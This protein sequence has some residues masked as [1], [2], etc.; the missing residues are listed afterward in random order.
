MAVDNQT[1]LVRALDRHD[2]QAVLGTPESSWVDFKDP[3]AYPLDTET[4][5]WELAKDVAAMANADGGLLVI[6]IY[7]KK[8]PHDTHEMASDLRPFSK[9]TYK[10]DQLRSVIAS[11]LTPSQ[12]VGMD[13]FPETPGSDL[14]YLVITVKPVPEADRYV[15]TMKADFDGGKIKPAIG[16]PVRAG[17]GT[18]WLS[19]D[20]IYRLVNDGWRRRREDGAHRAS[21]LPAAFLR[22]GAQSRADGDLD[23]LE[24]SLGWWDKPT[25]FWQ[26]YA[27]PGTVDQVN[28]YSHDG[29]RGFLD[30]PNALRGSGF[31]FHN[32]Y[33]PTTMLESGLLLASRDGLAVHIGFDGTATA[34]AVANRSILARSQD[35]DEGLPIS[36]IVLTELTYEY[37]RL[38]D[39]HVLSLAPGT[40]RHRVVVRRLREHGVTLSPGETGEYGFGQQ[41]D[42]HMGDWQQDWE[43]DGDPAL[44]AGQALLVVYNHFGLDAATNPWLTDE[45][46]DIQAFVNAMNSRA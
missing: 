33:V 31:H 29:I 27:V 18:R 11:W 2:A 44:D 36:A 13:W 32:P 6:G 7:A 43:A 24:R 19:A 26:S 12:T 20:E 38:A 37:F 25:V 35:T 15:L 4:S 16:V 5:K 41:H 45:R 46:V 17:D 34:G 8:G 9:T 28:L 22:V 10:I 1:E 39:E 42:A 40:W 21:T 23:N 3:R 14:H 30:G